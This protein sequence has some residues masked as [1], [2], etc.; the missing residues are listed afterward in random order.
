MNPFRKSKPEAHSGLHAVLLVLTVSASAVAQ[1]YDQNPPTVKIGA[2]ATIAAWPPPHE[3][4]DDPRIL[5]TL[6]KEIYVQEGA[7]FGLAGPGNK[8]LQPMPSSDW[9]SDLIMNGDGGL[10]WQ[11]PLTPRISN[12]HV[13]VRRVGGLREGSNGGGRDTV[14]PLRVSAWNGEAK[15]ANPRNTPAIPLDKARATSWSDWMV[16]FRKSVTGDPSK[17]LDVTMARCM[18]YIWFKA[19]GF[20]PVLSFDAAQVSYLDSSG[21][22]IRGTDPI[23]G[24]TLVIQVDGRPYG[25]HTAPGTT[26][27]RID[28]GMV[29]KLPENNRHLVVSALPD[30]GHLAVFA[31]HAYAKPVKTTVDYRY[32]PAAADG[33]SLRTRWTYQVEA[34]RPG[35]DTVLQGWLSPHY[36]DTKHDIKFVAGADFE[37]PRG[38]LRCAPAKAA[39]GFAIEY[40]FNGVLSHVA[41]PGRSGLPEDF[42]KSYIESLMRKYDETND[43][44]A[45][46]TYFGAKKLVL[47]A[48]AMHMAR[49]LGM[50]DTYQNIKN[51][52]KASLEDWFT[53]KE[54]EQSR[55][56]AR[57]DRWGSLIGFNFV[58]DFNLG[59][60]TDIHFHYGYYVLAYAYVAMEDPEF[61]DQYKEIA[62][63]LAK[64]YAEWDRES[65][66]YP[67][68]RTFEPMAG[69][70]YAGGSGSQGGNNQESSSESIQA[71]A[72]LFLLGEAL[73]GNDPRAD[74]IL[75]AGAFG[76]AIETRAVY[77]YYQDYHGSPYASEPRDYDNRPV[78][79][80]KRYPVWPDEF[81]YGRSVVNYPDRKA[82]V[83]TNGIMGDSGNT[84]AT[85]FGAQPE[86][87]YGI[88]WL[89]NAP[90]M[91]FLARDRKFTVGQFQTLMSYRDEHFASSW[92]NSLVGA[93]RTLRTEWYKEPT[94]RFP[95]LRVLS[96]DNPW[97][98]TDMK[99]IVQNLYRLNPAYVKDISHE[100]D[101][102]RDNPLYDE[103][104]RKWLVE[105]PADR[106]D[107]V[108]FP[109]E[110]WNPDTLESTYP[111]MVPPKTEA[112]LA[113]YP[114]ARWGTKAFLPP[115]GPGV[116]WKHLASKMSWDPTDYPDTPE[117]RKQ[118]IA[119]LT[120]ALESIGGSWPLICL[121]FAGFADPEL[122]IAVMEESRRRNNQ[123]A[124]HTETGLFAYY[125][126]HSLRGLGNPVT[127]QHVS[128]P[129]SL[130][131]RDAKTGQ[132]SY[133]VH[134]KSDR[135]EL[136][137]VFENGRNIGQVLAHPRTVTTQKG[138]FAASEGFSA[139]GTIPMD[140]S[141]GVPLTEDRVVLVFSEP[142]DPKSLAGVKLE[143]PGGAS[144]VQMPGGDPQIGTF[145]V[146]GDWVPGATYTVHVPA[147]V[148]SASGTAGK[149]ASFSFAI[150]KGDGCR[151]TATT[152]AAGATAVSPSIRSIE[153]EFNSR[154][155]PATLKGVTLTGDGAP[156][157]ELDADAS[158]PGRAVFLLKGALRPG[159]PYAFT[160]PGTVGDVFGQSLGAPL[161]L[162]F[163][164]DQADMVMAGF[165]TVINAAKLRALS[166]SGDKSQPF[167]NGI[168]WDF[169]AV[170]DFV[171]LAI[172]AE[173][174][175]IYQLAGTC[176]EY[177]YRGEFRISVNGSPIEKTWN[178]FDQDGTATDLGKVNLKAGTNT[179][180]FEAVN[181]NPNEQAKPWLFIQT[182]TFSP[183]S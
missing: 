116:D 11:Y 45:G 94:E 25:I 156:A 124:E 17:H 21:E 41:V 146:K 74:E 57:N 14:S 75:A 162:P 129:S 43:G 122:G 82:W 133:M 106:P 71:W 160:L 53:Y 35:A 148:T 166:S 44:T 109:K 8:P 78:Q 154:I 174:A 171:E 60:F 79:D 164:T 111:H 110:I 10:H 15:S 39:E 87:I 157:I 20:D 64:A 59:R 112:E 88:Q 84:F 158:K 62:I 67:W 182:L 141:Q 168:R 7:E 123:F 66:R 37:T 114:L 102:V 132:T 24:D 151:V 104:N 2:G 172:P 32:Q 73:R 68:M 127:D 159:T 119:Q 173:K 167:E 125:Y 70:S 170:G 165:D 55:Y 147:S 169:D 103:K 93:P 86:Y 28:S 26:F 30:V 13:E 33:G 121:T 77:E 3:L 5:D 101:P 81:R 63:E 12:N 140:K 85:Y 153:V 97:S 90:H 52:I 83:F 1:P 69:H 143:G 107:E 180:R 149:E 4:K 175:G 142:Y 155:N 49:E 145:R 179:L 18:P 178:Q 29:V 144:L 131:F 50:S 6:T 126:F 47:H 27:Q 96:I 136:A 181:A 139:I 163:T 42:D 135:F 161:E 48:R 72:G 118:S 92:M 22:E 31:Q 19:T 134:N 95:D 100:G 40:P 16:A 176:R 61:R 51:E 65:K 177:I 128:I 99:G 58:H 152:P 34:L 113:D 130:V 117:G 120:T 138:V 150:T 108:V 23:I 98:G 115:V 38:L 183:A 105:F 80:D 36:R 54:G 137:N 91:L 9:W 56:F 89:P 46:D 76:Y